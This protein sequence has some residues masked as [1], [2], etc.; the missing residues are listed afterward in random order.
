[1][2]SY[3]R[4]TGK[5][6]SPAVLL[7]DLVAA[8]TRGIDELTRPID[9]I[10]HQAKT[11]T[12]GISRS[13]EGLFDRALVKAVVDAGAARE[14]LSYATLKVLAA[15]DA[16]VDSVVG[17]TRYAISGDPTLNLA[18]ISIVER[19]GLALQLSSRVEANTSLMG[20]KRRVA[21]EQEVLVA[22]GRKDGRTV[23]FVPEV[24]GAETVGITLVH[25][26]FRESMSASTVRQVLQGYDRRYDRLVDWVTESEGA[27]REDRLAEVAIA[28]LLINPVSESANLWRTGGNQ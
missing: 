15:L 13:E 1:L 27:F 7:D 21:A 24:K 10:K 8:L 6:A 9:A 3:Q 18:T 14:Q 23:I 28:D 5:V 4:E 20:T 22:R 25:V 17:Y 16:A 19:G 11:V 2:Q 26:A 12:V